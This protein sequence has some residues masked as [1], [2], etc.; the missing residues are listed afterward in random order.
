[1]LRS[2]TFTDNILTCTV[3]GVAYWVSFEISKYLNLTQG[4][5]PGISLVFIPAGVKLLAALIGGFWG[6][7]GV[8]VALTFQGYDIWSEQS[9]TFILLNALINGF[10]TLAVVEL[11]RSL[12]KIDQDLSNIRLLHLPLIDLANSVCLGLVQNGHRVFWGLEDNNSF[13]TKVS[14]TALGDFLGSMILLL[15][16]AIF[17]MTK[18]KIT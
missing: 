13:L 10:S 11:M 12:L 15:G 9:Q 16:W 2:Q 17:L 5:A 7:V 6:I 8:V 18:H 4:F 14:A 1:M 3:F